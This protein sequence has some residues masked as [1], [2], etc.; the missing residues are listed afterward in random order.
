[1]GNQGH[2]AEGRPPGGLHRLGAELSGLGLH[3]PRLIDRS[4]RPMVRLAGRQLVRALQRMRRFRRIPQQGP[5]AVG[6]DVAVGQEILLFQ[7]AACR[8]DLDGPIFGQEA[9]T[10]GKYA[11]VQP[12]ADHIHTAKRPLKGR[13]PILV[14]SD[15]TDQLQPVEL[16]GQALRRPADG[17]R[18]VRR[19]R[20]I[21]PKPELPRPQVEIDQLIIGLDD[22]LGMDVVQRLGLEAVD[23]FLITRKQG[24]IQEIGNFLHVKHKHGA[25]IER[26]APVAFN[27]QSPVRGVQIQVVDRGEH[28]HVVRKREGR[29]PGRRHELAIAVDV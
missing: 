11:D 17:Q 27:Q 22:N 26:V 24:G 4:H 14:R 25:P 15:R 3:L 20:R 2:A 10:A 9:L 13:L 19:A 8:R 29:R 28:R 21:D 16:S 6:V 18:P 7:V 1:M 23:Q 12:R 5:D